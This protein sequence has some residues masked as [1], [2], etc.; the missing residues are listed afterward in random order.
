MLTFLI[1]ICTLGN[2]CVIL[3]DHS[4]TLYPTHAECITA[5]DA[6]RVTLIEGLIA[7]GYA[8]AESDVQCRP[9]NSA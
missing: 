8:V 1:L 5:A 9:V 3:E 7:Q 2:P 4:R 6:V